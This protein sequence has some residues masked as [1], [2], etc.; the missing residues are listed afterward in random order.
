LHGHE[1]GTADVLLN[2]GNAFLDLVAR[3]F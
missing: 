3:H 2:L 1:V